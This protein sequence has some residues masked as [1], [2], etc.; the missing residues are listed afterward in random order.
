[1]RGE[2]EDASDSNFPAL[3]AALLISLIMVAAVRLRDQCRETL[4]ARSGCHCSNLAR[5]G[6]HG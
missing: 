2:Q 5:V 4:Y 3:F 6:G 1:M